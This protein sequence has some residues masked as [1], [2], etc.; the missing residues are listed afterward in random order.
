MAIDFSKINDA[1]NRQ[2][3]RN[4]K[5]VDDRNK[6]VESAILETIS[7]INSNEFEEWLEDAII[8]VIDRDDMP[9]LGIKFYVNQDSSIN[10]IILSNGYN[11]YTNIRYDEADKN[12]FYDDKIVEKTVK[13]MIKQIIPVVEDRLDELKIKY[14][15]PNRKDIKPRRTYVTN[16]RIEIEYWYRL[17]FKEN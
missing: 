9:E 10:I 12:I 3:Q 14:I 7:K 8:K 15:E 5:T 4:Q 13:Q 2:D 11:P 1:L 6:N 16:T 17:I